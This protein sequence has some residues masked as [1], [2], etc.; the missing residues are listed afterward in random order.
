MHEGKVFAC[1][2]EA[3]RAFV[4]NQT[5][6]KPFAPWPYRDSVPQTSRSAQPEGH[7]RQ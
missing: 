4:S 3:G 7:L 1:Q 2:V 6:T 5:P